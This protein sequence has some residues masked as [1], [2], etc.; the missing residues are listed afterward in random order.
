VA[1]HNI[2]TGCVLVRA[3]FAARLAAFKTRQMLAPPMPIVS[4]YTDSPTESIRKSSRESFF[5]E[6]ARYDFEVENRGFLRDR[7]TSVLL[8]TRRQAPR[9]S[10]VTE[11]QIQFGRR[12]G[13]DLAGKSVGVARAMIEDAIHCQFYGRNDLGKA[14]P[15]QI[16]LARKFGHDISTVSRRVGDAII[17]DIMTQLNLEAIASQCL[18]PDVVVT[19]KHD[20]L[21]GN[22][23]FPQSQRTGRSIFVEATALKRGRAASYAPTIDCRE[24]QKSRFSELR[25]CV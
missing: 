16:E 10:F 14:T 17:D 22:S 24:V 2:E 1:G 23:L 15:K 21:G 7:P 25:F 5:D 3:I 11:A 20:H 12:I 4:A 8:A 19:N 9:M 18:A 6:G 13:L